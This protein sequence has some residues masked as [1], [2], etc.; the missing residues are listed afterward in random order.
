M[1]WVSLEF[2]ES[3]TLSVLLVFL[4]VFPGSFLLRKELARLPI[5]TYSR[6]QPYSDR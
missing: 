5:K 2:P 4:F 1:L 6:I 3:K